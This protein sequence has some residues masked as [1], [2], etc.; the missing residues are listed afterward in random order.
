MP[1]Q[2]REELLRGLEDL[3]LAEGFARLTVD[4]FASRLQCSK[5]TLYSIASSKEQL[6]A[7]AVRHFFRGA[8]A[9]IE[10]EVAPVSTAA[11]RITAYVAAVGAEMDRMSAEFYTD[12]LTTDAT[13][14][15]YDRNSEAAGRRIRELVDSGIASGDFRD[16][17]AGFVGAAASLLIDGIRHGQLLRRT[18]LS[19]GDAYSRLGELVVSAVRKNASAKPGL[20]RSR[21]SSK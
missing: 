20:V 7:A 16:V 10:A 5:S 21:S 12:M 18:G 1:D 11:D 15:I 2:R 17:D 3:L 9:R 13:A 19:A 14:G 8:T 4:D 6:V